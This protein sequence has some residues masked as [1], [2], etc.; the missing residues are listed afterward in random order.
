MILK[1]I[2][3][4][5]HTKSSISDSPFNFNI[6]KLKEYVS[7]SHLDAIAITNHNTFDIEQ[8]THICD[9]LGIV[10]F[11]GIEIDLN[12]G[13]IILITAK[14]D[15]DEFNVLC[16]QVHSEI[17]SATDSLT[18]EKFIEIFKDL[19]KYLIIPHFKKDPYISEE[20]IIKLNTYVHTGE[21]SSP[22]KWAK[23]MK[24]ENSLIPVLFS[25]LRISDELEEYPVKQTYI[26]CNDLSL[27]KIKFALQDKKNVSLSS[28]YNKNNFQILHDGTNASTML[29]IV[30]GKRSSGK[31]YTLNTIYN[32]YKHL[33]IKYIK[34][35]ELVSN[36]EEDKFNEIIC[37]QQNE[38][39][40]DYLKELKDV[41]DEV[42]RIDFS[43]DKLLIDNF[44][45]SL[46]EFAR[47]TE[48]DIYSRTKLFNETG[49]IP[50]DLSELD[51]LLKSC[52]CLIDSDLY[53]SI[54]LKHIS[55]EPLTKLF[56]EMRQMY[57]NIDIDNYLKNETN[58]LVTNI[59]KELGEKSSFNPIEDVDFIS[60]SSHIINIKKFDQLVNMGFVEKNI[61]SNE[62]Y[63]FIINANVR[64]MKSS[65]E[66][67]SVINY[68]GSL[69]EQLKDN[70]NPY[71]YLTNLIDAT[72]DK[73]LLYNCF[74]KIDFEVVNKSGA[75][76]SGG[77]KAEYNLLSELN[78]ASKY[79]I[80]LIDE[81]E[82]SFDNMFL[83]ENVI[84][85]IKDIS[86]KST[87]F[88]VTHNNTLGILI[89]PDCIIYTEH[90]VVDGQ[91]KYLTYT[92]SLLSKKLKTSTE[93][94]IENYTVLMGTMEAGQPAY[95]ER[96]LIYE[97]IKN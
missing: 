3:F 28:D 18:Y 24:D 29:N 67:K 90:T 42:V 25:D 16:S 86:E 62:I 74:W 5:I 87:V 81:P 37:K 41:V 89:K 65:R 76:L 51:N 57:I 1:K 40:D 43:N 45:S 10:V 61:L 64:Q 7:A 68:N 6:D 69:V 94:E 12:K 8:Y 72:I 17:S 58:R 14:D 26:E 32:N 23:T 97:T 71:K 44:L 4:H 80:V 63:E 34:Q 49:I 11:P 54:I 82:S 78:D 38:V 88:M 92:G 13:H 36:S 93:E 55:K 73:S 35:F 83:K 48:K 9:E 30:L 66:L 21:V 85:L 39:V 84:T 79:D 75:I 22:K 19:S 56:F 53:N 52:M 96:K 33:K 50:E 60:I 2:D 46:K 31:T 47:N 27:D 70:S 20:I 15:L 91:N 59:K 77:E 95:E